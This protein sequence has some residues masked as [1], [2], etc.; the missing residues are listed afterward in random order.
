MAI[1]I[2]LRQNL[3]S[4]EAGLKAEGFHYVEHQHNGL[5][6]EKEDDG[7]SYK[8][9]IDLNGRVFRYKPEKIRKRFR[10]NSTNN[11]ELEM[12]KYG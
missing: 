9:V 7:Y 8:A 11:Y 10:M 6:Y 5:L 12:K 4:T 1:Q 2:Y 3:S